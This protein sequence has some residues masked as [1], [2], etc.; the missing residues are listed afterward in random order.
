MPQPALSPALLQLTNLYRKFPSGEGSVTVL[1][2]I[3]LSI[4]AGEMVALVGASGSGK[5]TLMN[6]LGCLDRPSAGSYQVAGQETGDMEPDT[7]AQ[8]RRE[9]FGFIFQK[10]HLLPDLDAIGN[11]EIPAIYAGKDREQRHQRA[12]ALLTRVGLA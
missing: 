3:N 9:Y 1:D 10:Y 8:L 11:V 7:L 4:S 12:T 5:S 2:N 6:I